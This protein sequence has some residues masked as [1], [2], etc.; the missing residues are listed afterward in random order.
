MPGFNRIEHPVLSVEIEGGQPDR[1]P[2]A[3]SLITDEGFPS[4]VAHLK[5]PADETK[6]NAGDLV[7]INMLIGT[8]EYLLYK[9]EIYS[10][11]TDAK[12]RSLSLTDGYK[13]LCDTSIV[14][15]YRKEQ[16]SIILQD[17]LDSS[18]IGDT[19]ISCPSVEVHRFSTKKIPA[20]NIITLLIKALEEHNHMGLRFFFDEKN[21]FHFG[22]DA[23]SG[24]SE[25][26]VFSLE[27]GKNILKKGSGWVE[28]LPLPVRHTQEITVDGATLITR[29]THLNIAGNN[30]RLKLW[31]REAE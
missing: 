4:T 10:V 12:H 8:E 24:K 11:S 31:L 6:G 13:K 22:T 29:R 14:A 28:V 26:D 15:T 9:G 19:K 1:R 20:E 16:A 17:T 2:S 7:T 3:F 23:D 27:T 21:I 5:F 18:G 30:S 25:G